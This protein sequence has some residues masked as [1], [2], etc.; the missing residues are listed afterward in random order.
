MLGL[1]S[2]IIRKRERADQKSANRGKISLAH[3]HNWA[4]ITSTSAR[5][6]ARTS[7]RRLGHPAWAGFFFFKKMDFLSPPPTPRRDTTFCLFKK[8]L[9]VTF[10]SFPNELCFCTCFSKQ[11]PVRTLLWWGYFP[12]QTSLEGMEPNHGCTVLWYQKS[13]LGV[14]I[15][16]FSSTFAQ[17]QIVGL[18]GVDI[19]S[20]I[21]GGGSKL[22]QKVPKKCHTWKDYCYSWSELISDNGEIGPWSRLCQPEAF[23]PSGP[24]WVCFWVS[25]TQNVFALFCLVSISSLSLSKRLEPDAMSGMCERPFDPKRA[26][27]S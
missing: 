27:F 7:A 12:K 15:T 3:E 24:S 17:I 8:R 6:V 9:F 26:L 20:R 18:F 13:M 2:M 14:E 16:K 10:L 1:L 22:C 19:N 23:G 4:L 21:S 5:G 11:Y 25:K